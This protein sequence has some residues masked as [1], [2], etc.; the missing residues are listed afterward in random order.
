[1]VQIGNYEM[2]Q[3]I[4]DLGSYANVLPKQTW[5][6]IG[7]PTLQW[8]P[9]QLWMQNQQ[10]ILPISLSSAEAEYHGVVEASKEALW[11]HQILSEFGFQ[12]HHLTTLWCENQSSIQLCKD[13][14][15]NQRSKYNELHMH[16]IKKLIHDHVLEVLFCLTN[17]LIEN[18]FTKSPMKQ[19]FLSFHP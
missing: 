11:L 18:I 2:D 9:I 1:M 7:K 5:E 6:H 3:I 4:L 8:S 14:V 10:T 13:P 15:Q 12:Q 17:D 19:C 16:F